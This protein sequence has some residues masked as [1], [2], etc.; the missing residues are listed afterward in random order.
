MREIDMA[1]TKTV[2]VTGATGT[3]GGRV[4]AQLAATGVLVRAV[5]RDPKTVGEVAARYGAEPFTADLTDPGTLGPAF[6]GADAAFLVVPSVAGDHA[7]EGMVEAITSR[8]RRVVY[9]SAAGVPEDGSPAGA[10]LDSHAL[11]ERLVAGSAA[12]W[13]FLRASGFATNTLAW[14]AQTRGGGTDVHW[15]GAGVRR[16][17]VHEADLAAVGVHA[18][19]DEDHVGTRLHVTGPEQLSQVE[20][21]AAIGEAIGRPLRFV[22]L[23]PDDAAARLFGGLPPEM[24]TQIVHAQLA[25]ADAPERMSRDVERVLG[26]PALTYRRW[27]HDHASDFA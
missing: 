9:L 7:A 21:V 11:F 20:Q 19:L 8:V 25:M 23:D 3:V 27:A 16:A 18:L 24:A 13:T 10:I 14:A 1:D 15:F 22:E 12:E 4:L 2:V 26:R 17:L 6:D 5:G